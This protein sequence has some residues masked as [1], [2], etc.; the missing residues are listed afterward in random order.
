M[1]EKMTSRERVY[2][3]LNNKEP[4]RVPIDF[5][6]NFN[7][8]ISVLGH[9]GLKKH[10]WIE[11]PTYCREVVPMLA[12][13]DLDDGMEVMQMF[14][15]DVIEFPAQ[16]WTEW[17]NGLPDGHFGEARELILKDGS[18]CFVA[19]MPPIVENAD[20]SR[21]MILGNKVVFRMPK[22]GFYFDRIYNAC[23]GKYQNKT[24]YFKS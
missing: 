18:K 19:T 9:I 14:G 3:A 11:S 5:G 4:D 6:G 24:Y 17:K 1:K 8:G 13:T 16:M 21:D 15:S 7:S 12:C 10:L 2:A 22:D 20:G 23:N